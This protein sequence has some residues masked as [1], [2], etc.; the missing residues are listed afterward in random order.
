MWGRPRG[1]AGLVLDVH[2]AAMPSAEGLDAARV[3]DSLFKPIPLTAN[4]AGQRNNSASGTFASAALVVREHI[5]PRGLRLRDTASRLDPRYATRV[6]QTPRMD[7]RCARI[8]RPTTCWRQS[9][10]AGSSP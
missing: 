7:I 5:V 4:A 8:P 3:D 1:A 2:G 9:A 10:L 6:P